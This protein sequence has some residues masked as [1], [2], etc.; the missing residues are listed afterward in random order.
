MNWDALAAIG[1]IVGAGAVLATLGFLAIQIRDGQRI[2]KESNLLARSGASDK[3]FDQ[4][5]DFRRFLVA[6]PDVTRI[7]L[8]G[9]SKETLEAIDQ[10]RFHQLATD[11]VYAYGMYIQRMEALE[12]PAAAEKAIPVLVTQMEKRPGLQPRWPAVAESLSSA[13][14]SAAVSGALSN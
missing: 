11:Y 7:W 3:V 5:T 10:E 6:D 8:A 4:F 13:T 12:Q 1:E 14:V 2:Q 9:C